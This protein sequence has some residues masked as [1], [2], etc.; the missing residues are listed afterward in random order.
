MAWQDDPLTN[1]L[2]TAATALQEIM[3]INY[4]NNSVTL[5]LGSSFSQRVVNDWNSL[6]CD[7]QADTSKSR[8]DIYWNQYRF[9]DYLFVCKE[10]VL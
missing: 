7:P 1:F 3:V 9:C 8:L 2:H 5:M 6:P 4:T 10:L